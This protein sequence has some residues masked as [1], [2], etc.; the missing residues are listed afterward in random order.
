MTSAGTPGVSLP[1]REL[2]AGFE[3]LTF[4]DVL[5]V[6]GWSDVLPS[7]VSTTT[8]I[9][10]LEL[11]LP[12]LSAAMDTVTEAPLAIALAR[13]GGIGDSAP[14]PQSIIGSGRSRRSGEALAGRA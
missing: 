3:S 8:T 7:E 9:A 14:E 1:N 4:D 10:G 5:V 6:P 12:F 13:E 11:S 2:F